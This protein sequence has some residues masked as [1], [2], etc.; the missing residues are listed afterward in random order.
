MHD[1]RFELNKRISHSTT[2]VARSDKR[3]QQVY[4]D[5]ESYLS[6]LSISLDLLA[7]IVGPAFPQQSP[8]SFNKL[9]K[10]TGAHPLVRLFQNAHS[11]WVQR[12]KD[13][14]DCF[15]HYTPV[16]TLLVVTLRKYSDQW[17]VRA[18]LPT[19]PNV[20]EILEFRYSR[21]VE[22]LTY[23]IRLYRHM[24]R[25]YDAVADTISNLYN[26]GD[27]PIRTARLFFSG[28]RERQPDKM[29]A[30]EHLKVSQ[31]HTYADE[32]IIEPR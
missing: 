9:C 19:N 11:R 13:Y 29:T 26:H 31:S 1:L 12:L 25:F 4:W 28:R 18:K 16:D 23:V 30:G 5:F 6:E 22:L 20:R 8:L 2:E 17:E 14:R 10:Q 27:F 3:V 7:R 24:L 32:S 21:R 15:T